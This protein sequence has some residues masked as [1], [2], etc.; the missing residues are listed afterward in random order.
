MQSDTINLALT[1]ET[2]HMSPRPDTLFL[3]G[4]RQSGCKE[5]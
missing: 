5:T 2:Q 4:S 3:Q 1:K